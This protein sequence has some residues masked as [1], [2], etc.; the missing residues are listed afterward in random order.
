MVVLVVNSNFFFE[1]VSSK[2]KLIVKKKKKKK[3]MH[4]CNLKTR[5]GVQVSS[6]PSGILGEPIELRHTAAL[7]DVKT[8]RHLELVSI[9]RKD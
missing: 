9:S 2:K 4:F 7:H 3:L 5:K 1:L 8:V 6:T